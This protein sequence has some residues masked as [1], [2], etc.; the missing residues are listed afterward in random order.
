L[1][2]RLLLAEF[3]RSRQALAERLQTLHNL[4]LNAD[5]WSDITMHAVLTGMVVD[6]QRDVHLLSSKECSDVSHTA[7]FICGTEAVYCRWCTL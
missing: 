6:P 1:G 5:G 7:E 3:A 2:G 4:T